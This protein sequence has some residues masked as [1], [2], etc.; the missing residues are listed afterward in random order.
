M[1]NLQELLNFLSESDYPTQLKVAEISAGCIACSK[2]SAGF[3]TEPA[4][5]EYNVRAL[6]EN[7]QN[8]HIHKEH[9]YF[10]PR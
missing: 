4:E 6:C 5:F 8:T 3:S 2:N 10:I 1:T 9:E 7:F